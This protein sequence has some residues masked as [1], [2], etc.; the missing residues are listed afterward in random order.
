MALIPFVESK[1][2]P[3]TGLTQMYMTKDDISVFHERYFTL[4]TMAL[5]YGIDRRD[6]SKRVSNPQKFIHS[7]RQARI[8]A[9]CIYEEMSMHL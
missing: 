9:F 7:S 8:T 5:E 1:Q 4:P 3:L 2:N 6:T